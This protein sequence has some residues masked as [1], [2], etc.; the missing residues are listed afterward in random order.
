MKKIVK[1]IVGVLFFVSV[2]HAEHYEGVK[3]GIE[4]DA[5]PYLTGG[6]YLSGWIGDNRFRY[7]G[8]LT[9]VNV[10]E[11]ATKKGFSDHELKALALVVDYFPG[12]EIDGL[13]V[14]G[15]VELWLNRIKFDETSE[16]AEFNN[17]VVTAGAGY[18]WFFHPHLYV[19]PWAAMHL[20]VGGPRNVKV[21]SND[22]ESNIISGEVSV[23][24]GWQF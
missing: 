22:Y 16:T 6:Y 19:N 12:G 1:I 9:S 3:A 24:L 20:L 23:K 5:L 15:G 11:F 14:G 7:R 21:G 8:I 2:S 17:T 10:P 4:L 13:W 18:I